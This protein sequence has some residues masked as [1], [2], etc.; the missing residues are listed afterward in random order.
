MIQVT[1]TA[2]FHESAL[3]MNEALMLGSV[4]QHELT[5]V[6]DSL[7]VHLQQEIS[8]RMRAEAEKEERESVNRQLQKAE[9]LGVMAGAIAHTFNNQLGVVI[10]NLELAL[11]D[12]S[13]AE[14]VKCLTA[15]KQAA[16]KAAAVSSQML[17]YLGQSR[18]ERLPFDLT[19]TCE[20]NLPI[21]RAA[22]PGKIALE[23][24][25]SSPGPVIEANANRIQHV[26]TNL[27]NNAWEAIGEGSGVVHLAVKTVAKADIP[28][29]HRYPVDWQPQVPTYAVLE[30]VDTGC[31]I[32]DAEIDKI[33]D[34]FFSSKFTGRGMGLPVVM[35]IVTA[36]GGA[37]TVESEV[38]RGSAFRVFL[39]ASVE[40]VS[41][42]PAKASPPLVVLGGDTVLLVEDETMVREMASTILKRLGLTVLEAK[43]G[44]EAIEVFQRQPD[45]IHC[46]LC[47][48]T[49]PRM[50]GWET[51][52]AL[53]ELAPDLP[54][55]LASG[56]DKAEVMSEDHSLLPKLFLSKPYSLKELREALG[57]ALSMRRSAKPT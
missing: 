57:Q 1:E 5:E 49:M 7:N 14:P 20:R 10:G 54:V 13:D 22:L 6:A 47:D 55:I 15:A 3:A 29:I 4:R 42:Q 19:E 17:T 28:T 46:V 39:P 52:A 12:L 21:L 33:F 37:I 27:F 50:N 35:G 9:S 24:D 31:G 25:L 45:K 26:L 2:Q 43:D 48:L 18:G 23:L 40:V 32:A 30:L 56:Y 34:P 8:D 16:E 36:H 38:G 51:I 53:H 44:I 41:R 11:M